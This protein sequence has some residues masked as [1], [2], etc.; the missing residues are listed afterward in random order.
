MNGIGRYV[1]FEVLR[2]QLPLRVRIAF[3]DSLRADQVNGIPPASIIGTKRVYFP[4]LGRGSADVISGPVVPQIIDGHAY[5]LLDMGAKP[6]MFV[7]P[8]TGLMGLWGREM[9]IDRRLLTAFLRDVSAVG[10]GFEDSA[11][12]EIS[13]FPEALR[14]ARGVEYSG[15]YEDGWA[16]EDFAATLR[17]GDSGAVHLRGVVPF[18]DDEE[19]RTDVACLVDG[20]PS[21]AEHLGIGEVDVPVLAGIGVH[22][23]ECRFSRFQHLPGTDH[24]PV[25]MLVHSIG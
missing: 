17:V 23:I 24:R 19:F 1:L 18:I 15:I 13:A 6:T 22:K 11:P 8:R 12:S 3:T 21:A 9:Q 4:L 5:I 25:T 7:R 10:P 14:P 16:S 20:F 2:P